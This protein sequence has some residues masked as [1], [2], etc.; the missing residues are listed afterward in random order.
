M[1]IAKREFETAVQRIRT[2]LAPTPLVRAQHFSRELGTNVFFKLEMLQPTHS[3]KV[4]GA[5]NALTQLTEKQKKRGIVTASG[6]NHGLAIAYAADTLGIPATVYLPESAT[7]T[8][9]AAIRRF[10]PE[11]V[12]HGSAWDD[13]NALAMKVAG[14]S[15]R[16]YIH[17]FDDPMVMAG[18]GTIVNELLAQLPEPDLIVTSIGGGGLISGILSAVQHYFPSTR[19]FGVETEGA[20]SMYQSRK[21]GKIVELP[22]ITSIAE[23]LGARKTEKTQ[24]EIVMQYVADLVTV[25]DNAAIRALIAILEEEKLLCEPAASC[26]VAALMEGKIPVNPGE[27]VVVVLCGANVAHEKVHEWESAARNLTVKARRRKSD[28]K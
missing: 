2:H 26:S 27:K 5:F 10:G 24:F 4:R 23:T 19:V 17:P 16:V 3:F 18:Q 28:P 7:E 15:G 25:S 13:A 20:D 14:E 12:V 21:A 11:V 22:A 9:L 8:K 1:L 6:G